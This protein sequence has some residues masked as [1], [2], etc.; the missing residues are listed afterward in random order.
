MSSMAPQSAGLQ[1]DLARYQL[2]EGGL[3]IQLER[4]PMELLILLVARRGELVSREEIAAK[5]WGNGVFVNADQ[6]IN[7]AIRKLRMA[8]HDDPESPKFLETVVGKGYRFIGDI[9]I[10][11]LA[12]E[13]FQDST[14]SPEASSIAS[15]LSELHRSSR[16][17]LF[18]AVLLITAAASIAAWFL[19]RHRMAL[20]V[21]PFH[22]VAV[23]P[24][25]N[26]SG[27]PEQD[28]F[29]DGMTDELI[30]DLAKISSLR[31]ISRTSAM[32]YKHTHK[33]LSQ[34]ARELNVDA[35]VEGSVTRSSSR[36]RITAQLIDA[37][38]DRHLW[39]ENYER[40]L[41]DA[42][43][44]Q[45]QIAAAVA[46]EIHA[47]LTR[48]EET[49]LGRV[50][51]VNPAAYDAYLK[52]RFHFNKRTETDLQTA[53]AYF[54]QAIAIDPTYALAYVG[55]ADSYNIAGS[56]VF[57][58]VS[59]EEARS[60][61]IMFASKAL[62][63]DDSLGEAHTSLAD[64]KFLF[65]CDWKGS[66]AEFQRALALAPNYANAHH[67]HAELL[68]DTG[69][70]DESVRESY[71]ARD[72]DPLSP[73]MNSSLAGRL[74]I[75][76]RCE[77]A[78][79]YVLAALELDH[80]LPLAHSVLGSIY[81][82]QGKFPKAIAEAKDAVLFSGN[83][84]NFI[85]DLAYVYAVSGDRTHAT[86][87]LATLRR[88]SNTRYVAPYQFAIVYSAL[89][90]KQRALSALR[91]AYDERSPFLNNLYV[92][93]LPGGQLAGLRSEPEVSRLLHTLALPEAGR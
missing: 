77:E 80:N 55:L 7:R 19:V 22:S 12:S 46:N 61:A 6:S 49:R 16:W 45:S 90:D 42:V 70:F 21:T 87:V 41:D 34:I 60:K 59:R 72:L 14:L 40:D 81:A 89:G 83:N 64:A 33:P 20:A 63:I 13:R 84:P 48:S 67:W 44:L 5:L 56:W 29:A 28:Y 92:D 1:L 31:V 15:V 79:A 88:A 85:A 17:L 9:Q 36:V 86:D 43:T 24:L 30:T 74:C 66:E 11:G 65:D 78:M 32:Q 69:R 68:I 73:M 4:Q 37:K 18:S 2:L 38:D 93:T 53:L 54:N 50:R 71:K 52:G 62:A 75:S 26:L 3:P 47:K 58:A 51:P 10:T 57:T 23:L 82:H 8:L 25:E 91:R 35:V 39:A 76:G 27:D